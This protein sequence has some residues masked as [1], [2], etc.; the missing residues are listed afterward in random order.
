MRL[1]FVLEKLRKVEIPSCVH[2]VPAGAFKDLALEEVEIGAGVARIGAG[3]FDGCTGLHEV[4]FE[5]GSALEVIEERCFYGTG[6]KSIDLPSSV[7]DIGREAFSECLLLGDVRFP[8]DSRLAIVGE[9]AFCGSSLK[10]FG[11]PGTLREV[12]RS[13]FEQC[14]S[15]CAIKLN[16]GLRVLGPDCFSYTGILTLEVPRSVVRIEAKAFAGCRSL[17]VV[18]FALGSA[19]EEVWISA[20]AATGAGRGHIDFPAGAKVVADLD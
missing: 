3:A 16:E 1:G 15:I 19:L 20:F 6:L 14:A 18:E 4:S 10:A 2:A 17:E 5:A 11:C 8:E 12:R 7:R 9:R 13:A